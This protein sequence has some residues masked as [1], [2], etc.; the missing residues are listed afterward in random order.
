V[1]DQTLAFRLIVRG[2][3]QG[4]FFRDSVRREA[5][6]RGVA[7]IAANLPDGSVEVVLEGPGGQVKEVIDYCH[8]G[9]R[10]ATVTGVEVRTLEPR[11]LRGFQ[12]R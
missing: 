7:G 10:G 8:R 11:G 9:P 4:V 6:R 12:I 1:T 2:H 3:V 5:G